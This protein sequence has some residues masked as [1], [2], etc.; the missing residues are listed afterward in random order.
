[1]LRRPARA[2]CRRAAFLKKAWEMVGLPSPAHA[3]Q[4]A[5]GISAIA[6][7]TLTVIVRSVSFIACAQMRSRHSSRSSV[8]DVVVSPPQDRRYADAVQRVTRPPHPPFIKADRS[9]DEPC[10]R[11]V[12]LRSAFA[13]DPA[14]NPSTGRDPSATLRSA[15]R[16]SGLPLIL[17]ERSFLGQMWRMPAEQR[18]EKDFRP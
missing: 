2:G 9:E 12:C 11:P 5:A 14:I 8:S 1:M 16:Q 3:S 10:A 18:N 7:W 15:S 17:G 13:L 4:A 6:G